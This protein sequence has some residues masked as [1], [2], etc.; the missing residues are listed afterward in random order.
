[1]FVVRLGTSS[2][3][4]DYNKH[5]VEGAELCLPPRVGPQLGAVFNSLL[6][7][8]RLNSYGGVQR[9]SSARNPPLGGCSHF[10]TVLGSPET[11]PAK[12]DARGIQSV[13][14]ITQPIPW[15]FMPLD[16]WR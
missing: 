11:E 12:E 5:W 10:L 16:I 15:F 9:P 8:S 7:L 14:A 3:I 4:P 6:Y 1:M 2:S 13:K